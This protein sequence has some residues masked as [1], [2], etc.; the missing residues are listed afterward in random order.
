MS[1][2]AI[3]AR[4]PVYKARPKPE[5]WRAIRHAAERRERAMRG[6]LRQAFAELQGSIDVERVEDAC[7]TGR[8]GAVLDAINFEALRP[9]LIVAIGTLN[10]ALVE[11]GSVA[12]RQL[13]DLLFPVVEKK[14]EDGRAKFDIRFDLTNPAAVQWASQNAGR[15]VTQISGDTKAGVQAL[16]T[17]A[18]EQGIPPKQL[19]QLI[20]QQGIGLTAPQ[21]IALSNYRARLVAD[22]L[23]PERVQLLTQ[24]KYDQ[25]IKYRSHVIARHELL[26]AS[27]TG[28]LLLWQESVGAGL[29]P[30]TTQR[31]WIITPDDRLCELC[32]QMRGERA[33]TGLKQPWSTP[34]G[35]VTNPQQIHVQCRCAQG[36]VIDLKA[37]QAQAQAAIAQPSQTL[38]QLMP[39]LVEAPSATLPAGMVTPKPVVLTEGQMQTIWQLASSGKAKLPQIAAGMQIDP[40]LVA[41]AYRTM[42]ARQATI[43]AELKARA[44]KWPIADDVPRAM[45]TRYP[46]TVQR[47]YDDWLKTLTDNEIGSIRGYTGADYG[48]LNRYL[49]GGGTFDGKDWNATASRRIQEGLLKAPSPPPPELVWRGVN[50]WPDEFTDGSVVRMKG[51]QSTTIKPE[52]AESWKGGALLE[53]K[54]KRGGYVRRLSQH[55]HEYEFL[56]PHDQEYRIIGRR[57]VKMA[58]RYGGDRTVEVIQIEAL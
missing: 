38:Q 22:G 12:G 47:H 30:E 50:R 46:T 34:K 51:F 41:D 36:L 28:Q 7:A 32:S 11:G 49:R 10:E 29:I 16:V 9:G 48:D 19:A 25:Q 5:E 55:E 42:A 27:N 39:K 14:K 17:R 6:E 24:R 43:L 44:P 56:L 31:K 23:K 33:I 26:Q 40:K 21:A 13:V 54:P 2:V 53:I 45:G 58:D 1:F 35:E 4:A 37:A 52:F 3:S 18:F 15:L 8:V 20:Q 57:R